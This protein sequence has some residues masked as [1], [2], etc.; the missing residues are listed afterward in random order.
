MMDG[1]IKRLLTPPARRGVNEMKLQ[2]SEIG[3]GSHVGVAFSDSVFGIYAV[4][5]KAARACHGELVLG[6]TPTRPCSYLDPYDGHHCVELAVNLQSAC[7][8]ATH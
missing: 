8:E 4:W 5:G 7:T 3:P 6:A 2:I 1:E